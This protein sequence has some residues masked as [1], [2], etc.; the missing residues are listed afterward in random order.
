MPHLP[1]NA[2]YVHKL[3][4]QVLRPGDNAL[5]GTVGNGHDTVALAE[6]VG[7]GG[8]VF[9]F[10]IQPEALAA[11]SDRLE[12][13]G[14]RE[15]AVLHLAGHETLGRL[16]PAELQEQLQVA[17]FNLGYLPGGNSARTT[18]PSTTVAALDA[19][20][21]WLAPH[22]LLLV[23][24]YSG[25]AGGQEESETVRNWANTLRRDQFH[26]TAYAHLNRDAAPW[27]LAVEKQ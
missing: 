21:D 20:L 26:A 3:A 1:A 12:K 5:D 19:A 10:D 15:R 13:H 27:V 14:L 23:T 9:G 22:G 8:R 2:E 18:H 11:A 16:L 25:H 7:P 4:R 6:A 24:V 17:V